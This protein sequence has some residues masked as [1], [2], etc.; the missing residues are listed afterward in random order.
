MTERE[1]ELIEEYLC[2]GCICGSGTDCGNHK[3]P[4]GY[5]GCATH[6]LGTS[7]LGV[8]SLALGMPKGFNRPGLREPMSPKP[9]AARSRSMMCIRVWTDGEKP[10]W[11]HLN[12]P[13]WAMEKDGI[14]FARTYSPR[15]EWSAVDVIDGL[16]I[17]DCPAGTIDVGAF[18]D[19][20]D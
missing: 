17:D 14:L 3:R 4:D 11:N 7:I 18:Y 8:G 12:V 20:I 16:K 1:R 19:E 5:T 10:D 15:I 13:V 2:P 9:G 6:V